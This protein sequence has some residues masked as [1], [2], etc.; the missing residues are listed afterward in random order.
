MS[1]VRIIKFDPTAPTDP[2]QG[3]DIREESVETIETA[4]TLKVTH[5]IEDH[6]LDVMAAMIPQLP[7]IQLTVKYDVDKVKY[8]VKRI[9]DESN[10]RTFEGECTEL[11]KTK[12]G[13]APKEIEYSERKPDK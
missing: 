6:T 13:E 9:E 5:S 3:F 1:K 7:P 10:G 4:K 11:D 12:I 8:G 2:W